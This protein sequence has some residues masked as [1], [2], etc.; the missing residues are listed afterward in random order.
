MLC[1]DLLLHPILL[2]CCSCTEKLKEAQECSWKV[3]Q[4][5]TYNWVWGGEWVRETVVLKK[6]RF[7][8]LNFNKSKTFFFLFVCYFVLTWLLSSIHF[9][10]FYL[11]FVLFSFLL[12]KKALFSFVCYN[13]IKEQHNYSFIKKKQKKKKENEKKT[14][15]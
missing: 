12:T 2:F 3:I 15:F 14:R 7:F 11:S 10:L 9:A 13:A 5:F 8:F 6:N 1:F 4:W